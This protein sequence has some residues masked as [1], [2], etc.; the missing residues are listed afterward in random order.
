MSA[1]EQAAEEVLTNARLPA[2]E[3]EVR[4]PKPVA[5]WRGD[6]VGFAFCVRRE[7]GGAFN[8]LITGCQRE[9]DG[10]WQA[11]NTI[12]ALGVSDG[13]PVRPRDDELGPIGIDLFGMQGMAF[14]IAFPGIAA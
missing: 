12:A 3:F 14:H 10:S 13:P 6:R 1:T 8:G 4:V 2:G 7:R 9:R 5:F 11:I